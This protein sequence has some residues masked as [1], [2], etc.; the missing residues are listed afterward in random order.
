M[1]TANTHESVNLT[2]THAGATGSLSLYPFGCVTGGRR[3]RALSIPPDLRPRISRIGYHAP[4]HLLYVAFDLSLPARSDA[5]T[6]APVTVAVAAYAVAPAWGFR[7]AAATYY[8]LF[9]AAFARR[10]APDGIWMPFTDPSKVEDVADFGVAYHEGDNSVARDDA[11][12]I[13]SLHYTEPM[14]YWQPLAASVPRTY[15]AAL[16]ALRADAAGTDAK[17]RRWA[18]AVLTSG[19]KDESGRFNVEFQNKPWANGAVWVLNPNPKMPHRPGEWTKARLNFGDTERARYAPG[20]AGGVLDGEYL[21]SLEGWADHL[22]FRPESLRATG[23]PLTFSTDSLRPALPTWF[24][25]YEYAAALSG[26]LHGRRKLLF[27]NTALARFSAF[28]L[29]LDVMGIETNWGTSADF[30]PDSDAVFNFRR[31]MSYHKPYLLL[32]NNDYDQF[33]YDAVERYFQRCLFYGVFP[34]MFSANAADHAYWET[35]R[36][37][38]RDR[39]LFRK[40][41]PAIQRLSRAGW[42][43]VTYGRSD[44]AAVFVERFGRN[45][46]T[47]CNT[48]KDDV[49]ATITIQLP[50]LGPGKSP[51]V[52]DGMTGLALSAER[53]PSGLAVPVTLRA[54][55]TRVLHIGSRRGAPVGQR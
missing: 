52:A 32:Q 42:E 18:Q 1:S 45:D 37:Y 40:Y 35:P 3:G 53:T 54:G 2:P 25:V 41:I 10:A 43:P 48:G 6:R 12:G 29:V 26:E 47:V 38:N 49:Q 22:D 19:S 20:A 55:E 7:D 46:L 9:P 14:T 30:R 8:R 11:L 23:L 21:D 4:T 16:A 39:P 31:T 36:W 5:T 28:A 44:S 24:S 17:K 13:L 15:E 50:L 51:V 34:S 27:A 33:G